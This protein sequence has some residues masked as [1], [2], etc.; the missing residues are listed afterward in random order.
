[1]KSPPARAVPGRYDRRPRLPRPGRV[2]HPARLE[3]P[4]RQPSFAGSWS[5]AEADVL[6]KGRRHHITIDGEKVHIEPLEQIITT[7][8]KWS[9]DF[10]LRT[11]PEG[12]A[13]TSNVDILGAY[14]TFSTM[15]PVQSSLPRDYPLLAGTGTVTYALSGSYL[16]PLCDWGAA[17]RPTE[18]VVSAD[19]HG[20]LVTATVELSRDRFKSVAASLP[21]EV[22]DGIN[23]Y[24]LETLTVPTE[25]V[26]VQFHL[27]RGPA[28]A[29]APA[30]RSPVVHGFRLLGKPAGK[31]HPTI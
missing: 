23:V 16:S 11:S 14:R 10:N 8:P 28:A 2:G 29:G 31:D 5:H 25:S 24:S 6:Y 30:R 21:V 17:V 18:M 1:M 12:A 4:G 13:T 9:M 20:G 3:I 27:I 22:T 7:S 26:R 19:L 15:P